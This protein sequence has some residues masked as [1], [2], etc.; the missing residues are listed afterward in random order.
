[1][2]YTAKVNQAQIIGGLRIEPKGGDLTDE[3]IKKI[4]SDRWGKE[5]LEKKVLVI[6]NFDPAAIAQTTKPKK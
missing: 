4:T 3:D 1:M 6:E 5:L 2:K